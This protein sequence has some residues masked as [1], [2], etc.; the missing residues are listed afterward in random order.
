MIDIQQSTDYLALREEVFLVSRPHPNI[1]AMVWTGDGWHP[2]WQ[3]SARLMS[4]P[5]ARLLTANEA[6][7]LLE[8]AAA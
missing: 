6:A 4:R 5:E 7:L 2:T 1:P 8:S 3:T